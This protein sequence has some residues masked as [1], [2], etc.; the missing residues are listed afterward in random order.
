MYIHCLNERRSS[1]LDFLHPNKLTHVV[2]CRYLGYK[3]PKRKKTVTA[4]KEY[5]KQNSTEPL[6]TQHILIELEP[7]C[8]NYV[9]HYDD[10]DN[11]DETLVS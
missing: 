4:V 2:F 3:I 11:P 5:E 9:K 7:V 10:S 1:R 8:D 6:H